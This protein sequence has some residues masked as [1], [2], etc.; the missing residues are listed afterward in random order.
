MDSNLS[1]P[2]VQGILQARKLEW[3]AIPFSRG[4]SQP[5]D[6][7]WVSCI[8]GRFFTFWVTREALKTFILYYKIFLKTH[9]KSIKGKYLLFLIYWEINL[10]WRK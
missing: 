6:Q 3:V 1:G 10:F 2:S 9:F 8:A 4:F 7:I 5:R